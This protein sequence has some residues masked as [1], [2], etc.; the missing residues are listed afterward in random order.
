MIGLQQNLRVTGH[1]GPVHLC[2]EFSHNHK[3]S[4]C[5]RQVV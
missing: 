1:D 2:N 4:A 5:R 3:S